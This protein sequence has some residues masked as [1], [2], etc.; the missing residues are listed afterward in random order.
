MVYF[1]WERIHIY[2]STFKTDILTH[3]LRAQVA[4]LRPG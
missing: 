1:H 2:P 4:V 3:I